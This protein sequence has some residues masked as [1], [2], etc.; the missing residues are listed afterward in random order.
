MYR[1]EEVH[2]LRFF[3]LFILFILSNSCF[4]LQRSSASAL[5]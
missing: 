5:T 2:L 4:F 1:M 3:I